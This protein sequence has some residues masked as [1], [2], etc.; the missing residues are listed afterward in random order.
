MKASLPFP[1]EP[2]PAHPGRL[3]RRLLPAALGALIGLA[4]SLAR[5]TEKQALLVP[6]DVLEDF[7]RFI[8]GR[9]PLRLR[10]FGGA[11]SRRDVVE[12]VMLLQALADS[13]WAQRFPLQ[14]VPNGTRL[15][16]QLQ[17]GLALSSATTYWQ[18]DAEAE[19][20]SIELSAPLVLDGEFEAGF[21]ALPSN[22]RALACRTLDDVRQLTVLSSRAWRVDWTTLERL[23]FKRLMHAVSWRQMPRMLD[24]GRADVALAPFR[25]SADL[26][27][28]AE[29]VR[30][31]P[32]P[33]IKIA[34]RGTRHYL[35]SRRHPQS[36]AFRQRL[37]EG[38]AALRRQGLVHQA[39]EQSGFFNRQ[40]RHWQTH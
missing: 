18:Q 31:V 21:D 19:H 9:D 38:I 8:F 25:N 37:D 40:V 23:G 30:L 2:L 28:T 6:V 12:V 13:D 16:L 10:D 14:A 11:H 4:P 39:Y 32:I 36:E 5:G 35:I 3:P 29:G 24:H 20:E 7:W 33:G 27:L 15:R 22:R 34:L 26:A 17:A 1:R